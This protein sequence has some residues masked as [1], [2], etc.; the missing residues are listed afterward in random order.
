MKEIV[1]YALLFLLLV[2][3]FPVQRRMRTCCLI[4]L[5][6]YPVVLQVFG[7]DAYTVSTILI[8][9]YSI[10]A[11]VLCLSFRRDDSINMHSIILIFFAIVSTAQL[12]GDLDLFV[13]ALRQLSNF[14]SSVLL[15]IMVVNSRYLGEG[16]LLNY[17]NIIFSILI[18]STIIQCAISIIM[19]IDPSSRTLF[20]FFSYGSATS[21]DAVSVVSNFKR[22]NSLVMPF[23]ALS[24]FIAL[25]SPIVLYKFFNEKK[26]KWIV[27]YIFLFFVLCLN[28]TRSGFVLFVFG[29]I[30]YILINMRLLGVRLILNVFISGFIG[31]LFAIFFYNELFSGILERLEQT[32][33]VMEKSFELFKVINREG[34]YYNMV[35]LIDTLEPFGHGLVSPIYYK[36]IFY[37]FHNLWQTVVFQFGY[38][39]SFFVFAMFFRIF[40]RAIQYWNMT[41]FTHSRLLGSAIL[42]SLVL[43]F[44]N[45][46]KYEFN[47]YEGY[48]QII[49]AY[50]GTVYL[51]CY[52][53][54]KMNSASNQARR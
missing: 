25:I 32:S 24:E 39:G 37:H 5:V 9:V 33:S 36:V 30:I 35:Y 29:G 28:Q 45:E 46:T 43:F 7:R 34:F 19:L 20:A 31:L 40:K 13:R 42:L 15:F 2:G 53:T 11:I 16:D 48:Q 3:L 14:I 6:F 44:I 18:Y 41:K 50:L 8:Y 38:I 51:L 4:A 54:L 21:F 12:A 23:E 49:W 22:L 17:A 47:R 52:G 27:I 26:I 1:G 10:L